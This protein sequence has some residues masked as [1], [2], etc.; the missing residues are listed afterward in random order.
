MLTL[1]DTVLQ[2]K[3]TTQALTIILTV[4]VRFQQFSVQSHLFSVHDVKIS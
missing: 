4:A 1:F 3:Y 2:K